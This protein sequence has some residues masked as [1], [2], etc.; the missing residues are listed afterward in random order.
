MCICL[1][2]HTHLLIHVYIHTY[3][4]I[5]IYCLSTPLHLGRGDLRRERH[6]LTHALIVIITII[7]QL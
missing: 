6:A 4:Y 5:Y 1:N 2:T 7:N 3:I